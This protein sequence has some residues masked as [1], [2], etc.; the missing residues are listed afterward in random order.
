M[1]ANKVVTIPVRRIARY[2]ISIWCVLLYAPLAQAG[3]FY[4]VQVTDT[5]FG[6]QDHL[7]RA[8]QII[9]RI[10]ALPMKIACVV[11]TG[12]IMADQIEDK[13]LVAAAQA[14]M[15]TLDVPLHY[16]SGNHDILADRLQTT[17]PIYRA[18]FGHLIESAQYHGVM[19][20]FVYTEPLRKNVVVK[21]YHPL[22]ALRQYLERAG[23]KPVIVFH[24][25]PSV[26]NFYNNA[27]HR[28]WQTKIQRQWIAL[29]NAYNVKAVIAGHFHR[30][31]FHWLGKVPLYIA[32]PVAGFWGR[33]AAYR[34]YEYRDGH[35]SYTT[36][37]IE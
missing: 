11:H 12:D 24:H 18:A 1:I 26:Q 35:I 9:Q 13:K 10:N 37:Y 32:P 20:L 16:I 21:G 15:D 6:N 3:H 19:F 4:F 23:G 22:D 30:D 17:V 27:V 5:H 28:S 2:V 31:E 33:Q 7:V 36:Q 8:H 25:A 29:L 14:V 34:I